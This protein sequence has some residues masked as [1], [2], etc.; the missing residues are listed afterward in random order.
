MSGQIDLSLMAISGGME[1]DGVP[2]DKIRGLLDR[3]VTALMIRE[4]QLHPRALYQVASVVAPLCR[5]A[6]VLLII[7]R[8]VE[9]ALAV[10]ADGVHLGH[11][12]LP[13]AEA[14]RVLGPGRVLG[15]SVHNARELDQAAAA[16]A[17]YVTA[18]PVFS[19]NSKRDAREALGIDGLA[20]LVRGSRL[21]VV[22]LG[23]LLPERVDACLDA[24]AVGVAAIGALWS[25]PD[26]EAAAAAFRRR[27][28][29][30]SSDERL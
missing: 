25:A 12:G 20:E 24:G 17:D 23:G 16:G 26:P 6:G 10:G 5:A 8:S 28:D 14:R 18:S 27:L 7:N 29:A 30:P 3:G 15:V 13:P 9:V 2:V 11:D 22:A 19:P 4:K 1:P 21:P